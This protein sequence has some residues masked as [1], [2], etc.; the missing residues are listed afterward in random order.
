MLRKRNQG[1]DK[2]TKYSRMAGKGF[3]RS[4]LNEEFFASVAK[5]LDITLTSWDEECM[6]EGAGIASE[7]AKKRNSINGIKALVGMF[8]FYVHGIKED[9]EVKCFPILIK[10][11]SD[12]LDTVWHALIGDFDEE[13]QRAARTHLSQSTGLRGSSHKEVLAA[14]LSI[15]D[16]VLARIRP[17]VYHTVL[18]AQEQQYVVAMEFIEKGIVLI[19]ANLE[20]KVSKS[21]NC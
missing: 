1:K 11:L 19:G 15:K 8:K 9:G 4:D 6:G 12:D 2:N 10:V 21:T 16:P 13:T 18:N 14:R 17:E 5:S 3:Y 7:L 20:Y